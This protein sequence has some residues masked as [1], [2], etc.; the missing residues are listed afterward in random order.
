MTG[1]TAETQRLSRLPTAFSQFQGPIFPA[2]ILPPPSLSSSS[3]SPSSSSLRGSGRQQ[4]VLS[5]RRLYSTQPP[6]GRNNAVKFW[7]FAAIIALGSGGYA[8]M[9]RARAESRTAPARK[10]Q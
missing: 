9:I 10:L 8:L 3:S 2:T 4:Q 7:P 1:I 6:R 5:R